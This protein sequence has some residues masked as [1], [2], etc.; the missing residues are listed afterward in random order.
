M[1]RSGSLICHD[2][3]FKCSRQLVAVE[4]DEVKG[5]LDG[6][7]GCLDGDCAAIN[8]SD[9]LLNSVGS[10]RREV[11]ISRI[12]HAAAAVDASA[13]AAEWVNVIV[14]GVRAVFETVEA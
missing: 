9:G 8:R 12:G 3:T 10:G 5:H 2:R 6:R 14:D 7:A 11:A 1:G 13:D 4:S